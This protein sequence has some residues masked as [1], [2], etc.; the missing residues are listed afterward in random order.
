MPHNALPAFRYRNPA[1]ALALIAVMRET[2]TPDLT[3]TGGAD[4]PMTAEQAQLLK[5]LAHDAYDFEAYGPHL[6]Q[7]EA[8]RRI[9]ALQAKIKLQSDPPHTR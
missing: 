5:Q 6:T 2:S 7:K 3:L 9:T 1:T 8:A 4:V